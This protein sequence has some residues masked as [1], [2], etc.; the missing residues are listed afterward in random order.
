MN[1]KVRITIW[2]VI[3]LLVGSGAAL[4]NRKTAAR[5][6]LTTLSAA[7]VSAYRWLAM[8]RFYAG[9][10]KPG[11]DL[12]TLSAADVSAYRWLAMARFYA[13]HPGTR[14]SQALP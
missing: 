8:A 3:L 7:D 12:T 13:K 6:D 14:A 4:F 5:G 1:I 10:P 11:V 9:Q 2:I